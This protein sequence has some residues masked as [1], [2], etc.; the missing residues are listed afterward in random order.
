MP[1]NPETIALSQTI[2]DYHQL[3]H[4]LQQA[5]AILV[6]GSHDTRVA[7]RAAEQLKKQGFTSHLLEEEA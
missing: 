3:H 5:D 1:M 4:P 6:L 7:V 2:W